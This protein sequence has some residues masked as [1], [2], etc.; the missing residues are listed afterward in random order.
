M[1]PACSPNYT[2]L[3]SSKLSTCV[4]S[5]NSWL[6]S[7]KLVLNSRK[8]LLMWFGTKQRLHTL[9]MNSIRILGHLVEPSSSAQY[10]GVVFDSV[11][12]FSAHVTKTV[13]LCFSVLRQIKSI[14][15]SLTPTLSASLVTSLVFSRIDY[16][17]PL[18]CGLS[19]RDDS[20]LQSII[21]ASARLV[22][23]QS[24]RAH[25]LPPLKSLQWLPASARIDLRLAPLTFKCL[26]HRAP[27]YFSETC[28]L[29]TSPSPRD[30]ST[31]RMP[32]SA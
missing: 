20:R 14:R 18:L 25:I 8:T 30:L 23:K 13:S 28:L 11:H 15:K 16:C 31:S 7:N 6:L 12:S 17:A 32:S 4:D 21:N 3:L 10:L 5:L 22:L 2:D 26:N 19:S 1:V 9:P 29:Y 27:E 24:S